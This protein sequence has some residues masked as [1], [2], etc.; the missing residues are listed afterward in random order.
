MISHCNVIAQLMQVRKLVPDRSGPML[1]ILPFYHSQF[2]PPFWNESL[3]GTVAE[4]TKSL[5]L[6][7]C[8]ISP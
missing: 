4:T 6:S 2:P 5:A 7:I 1:G 8:C 3:R